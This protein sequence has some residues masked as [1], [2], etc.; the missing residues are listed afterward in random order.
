VKS[1]TLAGRDVADAPFDVRPGE[2]ISGVVITMTDR[3]SEIAGRVIDGAGRPAP[4]YPIVVLPTDRRYWTFGSR[5]IQQSHPASDGQ[6]RIAGLPAGE[7]YVC[8]AAEVAAFEL[9]SPEFLEQLV[10]GSF[11]IT[12]GDGERKTQDMKIGSGGY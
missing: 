7:Y 5:R 12:I 10:A 4:G 9:Y 3:I 8:A 1:V 6:Y 2:D 11:R